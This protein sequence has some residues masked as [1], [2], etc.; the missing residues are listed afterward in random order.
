MTQAHW[1]LYFALSSTL[2]LASC[3]NRTVHPADA[4]LTAFEQFY[5]ERFKSSERDHI[6][7]LQALYERTIRPRIRS[8]SVVMSS[9]PELLSLF[10]AA[11]IAFGYGEG[12]DTLADMTKTAT[13]LEQRGAASAR[14][15]REMY[16]AHVR[17][18]NAEVANHFRRKSGGHAESQT[19]FEMPPID[20]ST[21]MVVR[22]G[23]DGRTL[24]SP[25]NLASGRQIVVIAHPLCGFSQRAVQFLETNSGFS[26]LFEDDVLWTVHPSSVA[27]MDVIRA[28]NDQHPRAQIAPATNTAQWP[29]IEI[30]WPTPSI[31]FFEN[32]ELRDKIVGFNENFAPEL[33]AALSK[34][35]H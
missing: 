27:E 10:D 24:L 14:I 16:I 8:S 28:W 9:N 23:G 7:Q 12:S 20:R 5:Y 3:T 18:G 2:L 21:K 4:L 25:A 31:Y 19:L 1:S 22:T 6:P 29:E 26:R 15:W 17:S 32:G 33:R 30:G 35:D 11:D 13:M 34:L